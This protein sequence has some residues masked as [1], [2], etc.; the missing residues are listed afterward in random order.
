MCKKSDEKVSPGVTEEQKE[1][2]A[3]LL[4]GTFANFAVMSGFFQGE[5]CAYLVAVSKRATG[6][7][8]MQPL[9]I[10]TDD[11]FLERHE[12][13]MGDPHDNKVDRLDVISN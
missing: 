12:L 3:A 1:M 6:E 10:L 4:S 5:P 7:R 2:A 13:E 9:A 11:D 8:D